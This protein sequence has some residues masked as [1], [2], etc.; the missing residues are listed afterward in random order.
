MKGLYIICLSILLLVPT[1]SVAQNH[2]GGGI[3]LLVPVKP[4][5][6]GYAP[7]FGVSLMYREFGLGKSFFEDVSIGYKHTI[8]KMDVLV[9]TDDNGYPE[10]FNFYTLHTLYGRYGVAWAFKPNGSPRKQPYAG[11]ELGAG[12]EFE[13][14]RIDFEQTTAIRLGWMSYINDRVLL[15]L[16]TR[17]NLTVNTGGHY[18]DQLTSFGGVLNHYFSAQFT[19]T[20]KVGKI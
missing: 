20:I 9:G 13:N 1:L 14:S 7:G 5:S 18:Y 17:Y 2:W 6:K 8:G 16:E 4:F 11:L 19:T 10:H 15:G 12:I 3:E